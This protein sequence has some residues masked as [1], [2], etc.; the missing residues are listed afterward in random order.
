MIICITWTERKYY[1]TKT[2]IIDYKGWY[3]LGFIPIYVIKHIHDK[4]Y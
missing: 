2:R 4:H 3:L 1:S